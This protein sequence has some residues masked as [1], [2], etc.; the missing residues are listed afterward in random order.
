MISAK[1]K[2]DA[3]TEGSMD[4]RIV[5]RIAAMAGVSLVMLIGCGSRDFSE[6]EILDYFSKSYR[7]K[8]SLISQEDATRAAQEPYTDVSGELHTYSPRKDHQSFM[9]RDENGIVCE[10]VNNYQYGC[11]GVVNKLSEDYCVH[12]L[13]AHPKLYQKLADSQYYGGWS[14]DGSDLT[15]DIILYVEEFEDLKKAAELTYSV[16]MDENSAMPTLMHDVSMEGAGN[17]LDVRREI[18]RVVLMTPNGYEVAVMD[19][20]DFPDG[21]TGDSAAFSY[22]AEYRFI[23]YVKNESYSAYLPQEAF[24]RD[25]KETLIVRSGDSD[26]AILKMNEQS[27]TFQTSEGN[28]DES[29]QLD[30]G[31]AQTICSAAGWT[32]RHSSNDKISIS[33]G[34]DRVIIKRSKEGKNTEIRITKNGERYFPR[35]KALN[36]ELC[37]TT[38]D[39]HDLFGI[40]FEYDFEN[41]VAFVKQ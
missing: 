5:V 7:G 6:E 16:I 13:C 21:Y 4:I 37:L 28:S 29:Q 40:D 22:I 30:F 27:C 14:T 26:I 1:R 25:I 23:R 31:K 19:F 35:G 32:V 9:V 41:G 17:K 39:Y 2:A 18:P 12:W 38:A 20:Q 8:F 34:S 24:N 11:L 15:G 36:W 3:E 33:K 10:F